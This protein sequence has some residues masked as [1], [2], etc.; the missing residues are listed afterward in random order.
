MANNIKR[1]YIGAICNR[2]F[3]VLERLKKFLLKNYNIIILDLLK[4]SNS[5]DIKYFKRILKKY[6]ISLLIVKLTTQK[7]NE[8]IYKSIK[9]I[10]PNIQILNSLKSTLTCESRK[11]TF[12]L[13][14]QKCKKLN[15]PKTYLS[16]NE[17]FKACK[18]G[19]RIIIKLDDHNI[20]VLPK[21]DRIIGIVSNTNELM[22]IVKDFNKKDLFFQEYLGGFDIIYKVYVIGRWM[23]S[24][25][26]HNRL[27]D[28]D[29]LSPLE[30][31]HIRVPIDKQFKSRIKRLGR[32]FGMS[33]FGLDYILTEEG[34]YV[35]DINDFPSF[36]RIPEAISLIS[37]HIYNVILLREQYYQTLAKV[38][39]K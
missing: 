34:P 35:I 16:S 2:D 37:D 12:N 17:A 19:E 14:T 33:V 38:K 30:L 7:L 4:D 5:F 28:N 26:S 24:I 39:V 8:E 23:V 3:E 32:K 22:D 11:E 13:I 1:I 18:N 36:R 31:I 6:P 25:T 15:I 21:N 27:Q 10:A 9:E 20:P 29:N